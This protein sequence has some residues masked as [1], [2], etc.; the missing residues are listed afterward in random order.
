MDTFYPLV[1]EKKGQQH[2]TFKSQK[3]MRKAIMRSLEPDFDLTD[4]SRKCDFSE[5]NRIQP[6]VSTL[7]DWRVPKLQMTQEL[8]KKLALTRRD[9]R[10]AIKGLQEKGL[11]QTKSKLETIRTK[12]EQI[13][14]EYLDAKKKWEDAEKLKARKAKEYIQIRSECIRRI[15]Q[16]GRCLELEVLP[17]LEEVLKTD[18][19]IGKLQTT[20]DALNRLGGMI[21]WAQRFSFVLQLLATIAVPH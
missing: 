13:N 18:P 11:E 1:V 20:K 12:F 3:D 6:S 9:F 4:E 5:M 21:D 17:E 10:K 14:R 16:C 15:E 8:D 19:K 2:L 7:S